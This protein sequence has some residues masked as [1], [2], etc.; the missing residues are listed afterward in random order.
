MK[1]NG[2]PPNIPPSSLVVK[3]STSGAEMRIPNGEVLG[4]VLTRPVGDPAVSSVRASENLLTWDLAYRIQEV[5]VF[6]TKVF[7]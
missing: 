6:K 4:S 3:V 7:H 1:L 2:L 5:N